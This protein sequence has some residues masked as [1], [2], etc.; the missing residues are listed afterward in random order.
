MQRL[1]WAWASCASCV[2][3]QGLNL[4]G[5]SRV[6]V[7]DPSWNPAY[8]LQAQVRVAAALWRKNARNMARGH[9]RSLA[10]PPLLWPGPCVSHR[11]TAGC[12]SVSLADAGH[13]GGDCLP[14]PGVCLHVR[15]R[16]AL[17]RLTDVARAVCGVRSCTS[18]KSG[19]AWCP[20]KCCRA[21][22]KLCRATRSVRW[23]HAPCAVR[24]LWLPLL[25]YGSAIVVAAWRGYSTRASP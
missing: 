1:T 22:S 10:M 9:R 13:R 3:G 17:I 4:T 15:G 7:Y 20:A 12:G 18:N 2:C 21:C 6:I 5:A 23:V 24:A 8:D 25:G 14:A 19:A 16:M 11:T